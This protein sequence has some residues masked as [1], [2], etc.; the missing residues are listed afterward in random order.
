ML[1]RSAR[2]QQE[3][4]EGDGAP[5]QVSQEDKATLTILNEAIKINKRLLLAYMCGQGQGTYILCFGL[6]KGLE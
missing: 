6:A 3:E 5:T 4:G 2:D 1:R